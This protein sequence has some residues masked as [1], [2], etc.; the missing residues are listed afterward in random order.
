MSK[1]DDKAT[2]GAKA[3]K[4]KAAAG[5]AAKPKKAAD[6]AP[7][8]KAKASAPSEAQGEGQ[9]SEGAQS[10]PAPPP[11]LRERYLQEVVPQLMEKFQYRN[12]MQVPRLEKI[13]INVGLGAAVQ[14]PKLLDSTMLEIAAIT[15]QKPVVTKARKSIAN[16]KLREGMSIGVCVTLRRARMWELFDRLISIGLPRVRDFRG[17]SPRAFDG[18][19]NYTLGIKEQIVFPEIDFDK[20]EHS[21]GMNITFVTTAK[22]NEEA[23]SMLGMLGMPFRS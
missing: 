20:V 12:R 5:A 9:A 4:P 19:G 1:K 3:A 23:K 13:V 15:G 11:R 7:A 18:A 10:E 21:H 2:A 17:V 16:F 8:K 6:G 14:N 22:S